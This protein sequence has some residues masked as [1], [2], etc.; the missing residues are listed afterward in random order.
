MRLAVSFCALGVAGACF[1]GD[2]PPSP[3][4]V[5]EIVAKVNNEIVTRSEIEKYRRLLAGEI[6]HQ[7]M[8][9]DRAR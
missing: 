6:A 7:Q 9:P 1:A 5:E 2:T 8:T 4:V 3:L